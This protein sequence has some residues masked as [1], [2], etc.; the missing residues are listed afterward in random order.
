MQTI[1]VALGSQFLFTITDLLARNY[2][3]REGFQ[4]KTFVSGWFL[5]YCLLK[6]VATTGQLYVF[7]TTKLG[8]TMALFSA[9]SIILSNVLGVLFLGEML[10]RREY[11]GIV[12][13]V[14]AFIVLGYPFIKI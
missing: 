8:K 2:M 5:I 11:V 3:P 12:L 14:C 10:S 13:A 9:I 7:T 4:I 1:W 6:I